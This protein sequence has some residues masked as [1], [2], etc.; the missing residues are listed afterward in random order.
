MPR[1]LRAS[2]RCLKSPSTIVVVVILGV[3]IGVVSTA[4]V[5]IERLVLRPLPFPNQERLLALSG[6]SYAPATGVDIDPWHVDALQG[7]A[8]CRSGSAAVGTHSE[9]A[10][11]SAARAD[12]RR[13]ATKPVG[14]ALSTTCGLSQASDRRPARYHE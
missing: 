5:L 8:V 10:W 2:R 13:H 9:E 7:L 4:T 12:G 11:V 6:L 1:D 3:A 14:P